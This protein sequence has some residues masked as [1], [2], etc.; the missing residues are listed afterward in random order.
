MWL[1]VSPFVQL[2]I[3]KSIRMSM[4]S[5]L[6][7]RLSQSAHHVPVAF[8]AEVLRLVTHSSPRTWG[9]TRDKPKNV[10]VRG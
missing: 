3:C 5:A 7:Q 1:S 9:G 6:D 10:R 8:Y 4:S 2:S